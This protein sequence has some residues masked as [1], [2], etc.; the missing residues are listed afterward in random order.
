MDA[1][2]VESFSRKDALDLMQL[3]F[4]VKQLFLTFK[5]EQVKNDLFLS[6]VL[7]PQS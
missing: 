2:A 3:I 4:N 5:Y 1:K 6:S 7:P